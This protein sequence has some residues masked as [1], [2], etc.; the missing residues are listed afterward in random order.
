[1]IPIP[2]IAIKAI[3][4]VAALAI[5]GG[6]GYLKGRAAV[7]ES[8]DA[9]VTVQATKSYSQIIAEAENAAVS[10]VRYIIVQGDTKTRIQVVEQKV[11]EYVNAP[12]QRCA[13]DADF[14]D[15]WD[16]A[17][18]VYNA[19][20][21]RLPAADADPADAHELPG[22]AVTTAEVVQAYHEAIAQLAR[23][24]DAYHALAQFDAGRFV[25]QQTAHQGE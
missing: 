11:V 1:V 13:V 24:R 8:W 14:V 6:V 19:G 20:L 10:E 4:V 18:G 15:V 3:G 17:S 23:Y 9:A 22:G 21:H 2:P 5:A 16:A 25:V 7:Q 12:V